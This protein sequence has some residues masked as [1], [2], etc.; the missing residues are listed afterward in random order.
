MVD[1]SNLPNLAGWLG[2]APPKHLFHY[3]SPGGF[4]G[5]VESKVLFAGRASDMNDYTEQRKA[6][7]IVSLYIANARH[8][9]L[10]PGQAEF[11]DHLD[12]SKTETNRQVFTVSLS[13]ER[14]SLEQWRAYSPR[15]GGVALGLPSSHLHVAATD[16]GYY[17]AACVYDWATQCRIIHEIIEFHAARFEANGA[18]QPLVRQK[19]AETHA[20]EAAADLALY[21]AIIKDPAFVAEKEWRLVSQPRTS[22]RLTFRP[23]ESGYRVYREFSLLTLNAPRFPQENFEGFGYVI[24]PNTDSDAMSYACQMLV[25]QEVE[26]NFWMTATSAP[27]R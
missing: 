8:R 20:R 10:P 11:W 7:E 21:G 18:T 3:T 25:T 24:G 22:E 14:D 9:G 15:S 26:G 23:T 5:I 6:L 4:K 13:E 16:Q 19:L 17:L 2:A 12:S 27:Y 1:L